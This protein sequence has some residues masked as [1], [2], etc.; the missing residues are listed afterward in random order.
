MKHRPSV[1]INMG[2]V[3]P[4]NSFVENSNFIYLILLY[5]LSEIKYLNISNGYKKANKTIYF[6]KPY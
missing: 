4:T 5:H 2:N 6:G 3:Y 1:F